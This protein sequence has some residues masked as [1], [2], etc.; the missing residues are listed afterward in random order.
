MMFPATARNPRTTYMTQA[1]PSDAACCKAC[2]LFKRTLKSLIHLSIDTHIRAASAC[3]RMCTCSF[4]KASAFAA[5][6]H[7]ES[8]VDV[9][10][11]NHRV[12]TTGP[13]IRTGHKMQAG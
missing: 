5:N 2:K 6:A 9:R 13:S 11:S 8:T 1:A 10:S 12:C 7:V 3:S 4:I